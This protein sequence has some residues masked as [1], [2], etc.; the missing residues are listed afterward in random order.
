[1]PGLAGH[2]HQA[3]GTPLPARL[4]LSE[5][6]GPADE[7]RVVRAGEHHGQWQGLGRRFRGGR[8]PVYA[9]ARVGLDTSR[10]TV[11]AKL[12]DWVAGSAHPRTRDYPG[13]A[14]VDPV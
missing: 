2:D 10:L 11:R 6:S 12:W 7:R 3:A 1:M 4:E 9:P 14:T 13:E 5:R 8:T